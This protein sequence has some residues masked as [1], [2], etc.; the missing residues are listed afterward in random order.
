MAIKNG[1]DKLDNAVTFGTNYHRKMHILDIKVD[2]N[3]KRVAAQM[4][5]P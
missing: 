2:K 3:L 5:K 4:Q 1:L